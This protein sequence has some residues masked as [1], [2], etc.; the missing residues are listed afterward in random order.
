M[1]NKNHSI[2]ICILLFVIKTTTA[3]TTTSTTLTFIEDE[4]CE[5][6]FLL[7]PSFLSDVI[8]TISTE[9]KISG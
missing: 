9:T 7:P 6:R 4:D 3:A 8:T 2:T 1:K 5:T